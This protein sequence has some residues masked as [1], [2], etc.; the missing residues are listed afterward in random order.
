[1][2]GEFQKQKDGT[3]T[4]SVKLQKSQVDLLNAICDTLGVNS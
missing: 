3:F 2:I 1:M 4:V